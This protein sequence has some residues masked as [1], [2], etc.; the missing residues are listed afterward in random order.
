MS[1]KQLKLTS[2][3]DVLMPGLFRSLMILSTSALHVGEIHR[4]KHSDF[5]RLFENLQ[6]IEICWQPISDGDSRMA[7]MQ[8][9]VADNSLRDKDPVRDTACD[10]PNVPALSLKIPSTQYIHPPSATAM[11]QF[12]LLF[13]QLKLSGLRR[14]D[15]E[16][17]TFESAVDCLEHLRGAPNISFPNLTTIGLSCKMPIQPSGMFFNV[18]VGASL[19]LSRRDTTS[20]PSSS[21]CFHSSRHELK[22]SCKHLGDDMH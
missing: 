4:V 14:I 2:R 22:G 19:S 11:S 5:L 20:A 18:H 9:A 1:G 8:E 16:F 21:S 12:S 15:L 13:L 7:G 17:T 10:L 6:N 3:P